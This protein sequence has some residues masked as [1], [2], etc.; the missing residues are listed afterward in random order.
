MSSMPARRAIVLVIDACGVG[1]LP[2]A[3]R[4]GDEG[5]NTLLHVAEALPRASLLPHPSQDSV[6]Q[7]A[8]HVEG[9]PPEEL[10][11][12]CAAAREEMA[13]EHAVGRIIARPFTGRE[14]RF[15]R[16]GGRRDFALKPPRR[17]Y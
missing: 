2:D 8:A 6:L 10:Y 1:A 7:P 5:T 3:A 16:T 12:A 15:R 11:R 4:Y 17:S 14:G 13:A 9:V